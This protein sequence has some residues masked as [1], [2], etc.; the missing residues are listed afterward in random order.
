V[1]RC[2]FRAA[3]GKNGYPTWAQSA[4]VILNDEC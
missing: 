4:K 1:R 2:L 3:S